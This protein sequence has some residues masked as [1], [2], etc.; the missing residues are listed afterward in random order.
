MDCE[1][2]FAVSYSGRQRMA[3]LKSSYVWGDISA[4]LRPAALFVAVMACCHVNAGSCTHTK[5]IHRPEIF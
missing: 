1:G 4:Y 3:P 2:N 5:K